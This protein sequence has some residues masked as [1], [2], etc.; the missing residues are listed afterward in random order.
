MVFRR[1]F[2]MAAYFAVLEDADVILV[3]EINR[4]PETHEF[5][6]VFPC[7][8]VI[9]KTLCNEKRYELMY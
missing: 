7:D 5:L 2:E 6:G 4:A 9:T 1:K 8:K 3:F